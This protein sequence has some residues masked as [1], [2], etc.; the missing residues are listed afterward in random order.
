VSL[1]GMRLSSQCGAWRASARPWACAQLQCPMGPGLAS[2]L[3]PCRRIARSDNGIGISEEDQKSLFQVLY[4]PL[5][6]NA[7]RT[8]WV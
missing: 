2:R 4:M 8:L 3:T 5:A 7:F 6:H 1:C